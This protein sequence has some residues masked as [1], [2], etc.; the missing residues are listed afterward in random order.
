MKTNP[1]PFLTLLSL[2][3]LAT[4][5][6]GGCASNPYAITN[7]SYK[8]QAKAY[9]KI[10]GQVPPVTTGETPPDKANW[11][12]TTNF[13]LRKPNYVI[14][15]H[16]AQNSTEQTL[17]TFTLP[18]T[19]VSAHY[20]IGKDGKVYH[21]LN[22]YLRAWQAGNAKWGGNT[23]INSNS[24]GIELDNNGFVPFPEAQINSLLLL[25]ANLK[26]NYNIPTANFIGHGDIAP[27]RKN[28]PNKYF[29]WKTLAEHGFG[30]WYDMALDTVPANFNAL[31]AMR[32]IGYDTRDSI[33][34]LAAFK[35]HFTPQ[36]STRMVTD[37]SRMILNNLIRKY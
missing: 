24:I 10:I 32:I 6:L 12:G 33:A 4:L 28:D 19:Q 7:R 36:D 17:K 13:N 31:Q 25:L 15:H 9:A 23:D 2:F 8:K 11:V 22:D 16:T 18:R 37:S 21:M 14:I 3:T 30:N 27:T 35:R 29:P 5:I 20:V 26:K 1:F 34:A